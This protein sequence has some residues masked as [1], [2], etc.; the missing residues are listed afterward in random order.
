MLVFEMESQLRRR[1]IAHIREPISIP[2][3]RSTTWTYAGAAIIQTARGGKVLR[4]PEIHGGGDG[5]GEGWTAGIL[6]GGPESAM[7]SGT[8]SD[9]GT[10]KAENNI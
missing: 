1:R 7:P 9:Y 2:E 6:F 5:T 3:A 4:E 10:L 8:E